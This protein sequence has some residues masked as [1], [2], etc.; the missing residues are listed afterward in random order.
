MMDNE[1]NDANSHRV[2]RLAEKFH[3]KEYRDTYVESHTRRFLAHQMRKFRGEKSQVEFGDILNKRQTIVW[4]LEDPNYS[5]W[6]LR[7]LFQVAQKLNVAVVAR[8]V[9]FQTFLRF[10][11][12]TSE[13]ALNPDSYNEAR[14]DA[15]AMDKAIPWEQSDHQSLY[16]NLWQANQGTTGVFGFS[17]ALRG[18]LSVWPTGLSCTT[19]VETWHENAELRKENANLKE[20]NARLRSEFLLRNPPTLVVLA[21]QEAGDMA[22][23]R[24]ELGAQWPASRWQEP[25]GPANRAFHGPRIQEQQTGI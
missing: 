24:V 3:N 11:D 22:R 5:G 19:N 18:P 1:L 6:T 15:F 2:V 13:S 7:T 16:G 21:A 12:D 9:N 25:L 20:E 14:V 4:R 10:T 23:A 17:N 8:F